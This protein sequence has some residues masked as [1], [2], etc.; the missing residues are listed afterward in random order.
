MPFMEAYR[1]S[2][3]LGLLKA[4]TAEC[5]F[6]VRTLHANLDFA[7]LIGLDYYDLLCQHRGPMIG[8][9]LFSVAAFRYCSDPGARMID[10]MTNGLSHLGGSHLELRERLLRI[11]NIDVPAYLDALV[12]S[13]SWAEAT[14]VGFSSTFQQ[15]AASFALARR[16]KRRHPHIVTVFGG[17]NFDS[18]MGP[19]LVRA[20]DC[21]D[22]AVTCRARDFVGRSPT[23]A[24]LHDCSIWYG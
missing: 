2:I 9:W 14:V 20:I 18:E 15:N 17:A 4:L 23:P 8:D 12:D 21:I 6:P 1:P 16:L 3:Q 5:G 10:D 13:F 24:A 7:A 11:R 19:E 22:V